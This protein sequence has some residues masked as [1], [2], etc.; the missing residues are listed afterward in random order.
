MSC[1]AHAEPGTPIITRSRLRLQD[2]D[3]DSSAIFRFYTL[4]FSM[5]PASLL[6]FV[7]SLIVATVPKVMGDA[8]VSVS[9]WHGTSKI[10]NHELLGECLGTDKIYFCRSHRL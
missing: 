4:Q 2:S 6:A 1:I 8:A 10:E 5:L 3:C 7:T 9:E